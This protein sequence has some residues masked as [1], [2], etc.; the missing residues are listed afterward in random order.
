MG[1][2]LIE[3]D[4]RFYNPIDNSGDLSQNPSDFT[5][6]LTGSVMEQERLLN[7][8]QIRWFSTASP[9]DTFEF[10]AVGGGTG[11]GNI[12]NRTTG[13]FFAD[14][15]RI[16]DRALYFNNLDINVAQPAQADY[17]IEIE[18]IS[19]DG[20]S[21]QFE[22]VSAVT[23]PNVISGTVDN[24]FIVADPT[25]AESYLTALRYSFGIIGNEEATNYG[26]KT[27]GNEQIYSGVNIGA[28]G[29]RS[30]TFV[31]MLP[32]GQ[33]RDWV[34]G[35]ARVRFVQNNVFF[36]VFEIEHIYVINPYYIDGQLSNL[37][38]KIVPTDLSGNNSYKYA[39][40]ADFRKVISD[41]NAGKV[42]VKDN[43]QGSVGW[44]QENFN[45]LPSKYQVNSITYVD[46]SSGQPIEGIATAGTT[47]ATIVVE[48]TVGGDFNPTDIYGICV[49]Y[50]P[51]ADEYTNKTTDL[52]ENFLYDNAY[53][54]IGNTLNFTGIIKRLSSSAVTNTL[55]IEVD[56]S[57]DTSQQLR[58]NT[59]SFYVL[60]VH[61]GDVTSP[62]GN[63][64]RVMLISDVTNY[65]APA[66]IPGLAGVDS[67]KF[68]V[69]GEELGV[70]LGNDDIKTWDEDGI[71]ATFDFWLDRS[72][73]S[74]ITALS[75]D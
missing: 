39:Y 18:G 38:N 30:T 66:L 33:Y 45:G 27:T 36:Q 68:L 26:S 65:Q 20:Q 31:D 74:V 24:A 50:L 56:F 69:H 57:Y 54:I 37:Q 47:R 62:A 5:T 4:T 71:L 16:G 67:F 53:S 32:S 6:N 14:G 46:Q 49:S 7:Q 64:D 51:T 61:V 3:V 21:M 70:D 29:V 42:F 23:I 63:S 34:T 11:S 75:V 10:I 9:A 1:L 12:V 73:E 43:K 55:T 44:F 13:N 52:L 35:T 60:A 15:F 8:I 41:P 25:Q 58:I 19:E 59:E 28:G 22:F 17:L 40:R 48:K 72:K 2:E